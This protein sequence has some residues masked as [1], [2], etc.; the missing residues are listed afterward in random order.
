MF[1][2]GPF[3][4][5]DLPKKANAREVWRKTVD[6]V[7][8]QESAR[9]LVE[10]WRRE[11][12]VAALILGTGWRGAVPSLSP[13]AS[14][15]YDAIPCLGCP[16]VAGHEGRLVL[17]DLEGCP[18]LVFFGRRH[19]YEGQGWEPVAFPIYLSRRLE[20]SHVILTNAAGGIR[21]DLLP[22]RL[23]RITDHIN[24]MGTNPFL[25]LADGAWGER[26]VDQTEV[27][28]ADLGNLMDQA[29]RASNVALT[30][31]VYAAVSGPIFETPAEVRALQR[32]GADAVGMSTVPEAMLA[33]AAG[34]PVVALSCVAN[35]A[36]GLGP[37]PVRH[38][39]VLEVLRGAQS[40]MQRLLAAFFRKLNEHP[41]LPPEANCTSDRP[42]P[43]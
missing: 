15:G 16:S 43:S 35:R 33:H 28:N 25:G 32:L 14:V 41:R 24:M 34:L 10:R 21:P 27:Y 5:H 42:H 2:S 12:P 8:L 31:G 37:R 19:W 3:V 29:A 22:G 9:P 1:F 6:L 18:V 11:K 20:I 7:R 17:G 4:Y 39:E 40:A 36:A 23:L 38:E 30:G 26:F 13:R